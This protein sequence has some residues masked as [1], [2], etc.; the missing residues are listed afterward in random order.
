MFS[1]IQGN[2]QMINISFKILTKGYIVTRVYNCTY[3]VE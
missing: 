3:I 1:G 2:S